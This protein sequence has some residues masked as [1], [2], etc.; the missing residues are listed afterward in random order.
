MSASREDPRPPDL[1]G[2]GVAETTQAQP[3]AGSQGAADGPP[4]AT[5]GTWGGMRLIQELGRGSFGRVYRAWDDTLAREVALKIIPL[6]GA[7]PH[8]ARLY[9]RE[10]QMLARVRHHNVVT[11]H[12]ALHQGDEIGIW[13][14][15]VRGRR[16]ADIVTDEGPLGAEE[17]ALVGISLCHALAAVHR[18]GLLHRDLKAPNVMR[19]EGGRIVLMDF[20]AGRDTAI[21]PATGDYSGTPLYMAPEILAGREAS[22]A[23][24]VYSLGV[25]LYFLVSG[26]YPVEGRT[27]ADLAVAH[28]M[29]RRVR[30]SDRRPDLPDHFTRVVERASQPLVSARYASAGALLADLDAIAAG[31][32]THVY[33]ASDQPVVRPAD[34]GAGPRGR[35]AGWLLASAGV[36]VVV[37]VLGFLT[38]AAFDLVLGRYAGFVDESPAERLIYGVRSL[39]AP[40]VYGGALV[41]ALYA[42]AA[43]FRVVIRLLPVSRRPVAAARAALAS[44]AGRLG[45]RD[46]RSIA[47]LIVVLQALAIVAVVLTF[48][49]LLQASTSFVNDGP[50]ALLDAL[51]PDNP[52]RKSFRAVLAMLATAMMLVWWKL[53][54]AGSDRRPDR[55]TI[56]AGLVVIAVAVVLMSVPYRLLFHSTF[57]RVEYAGQRC[58]VLGERPRTRPEELLLFCRQAPP[59]RNRIVRLDDERLVRSGSVPEDI[60]AGSPAAH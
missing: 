23:S 60:F 32:R 19:E 34:A 55:P 16:L 40:A 31:A 43:V 29:A 41:V 14:E 28:G 21:T 1:G 36:A 46:A 18:A 53:L 39:V 12:G 4:I 8:L 54:A 37:A 30:L 49:E 59:P 13:M 50:A 7:D 42:A 35:L 33:D 3:P 11:V 57:E 2:L 45:L 48:R 25:L 44:G 5:I 38:S 9:L 10:G 6:P 22:P 20:G 47:P 58:Y 56:G 52:A 26:R 51:T 17:A 27:A 24:D 15:F